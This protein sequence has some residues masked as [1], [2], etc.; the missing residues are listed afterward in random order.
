M[1]EASDNSSDYDQLIGPIEKGFA[2]LKKYVLQKEPDAMKDLQKAIDF[3]DIFDEKMSYGTHMELEEGQAAIKKQLDKIDQ[4][5]K[6]HKDTTIAIVRKDVKDRTEDEKAHLAKMANL[7]KKKKALLD[8]YGDAV[9]GI[10]KG[11]ELD[12]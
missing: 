5:L 2:Y 4:A 10:N 12:A 3:F 9:A 11:Q 1:D 7:T 8:K 6:Q